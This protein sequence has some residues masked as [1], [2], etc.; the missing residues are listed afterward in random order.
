MPLSCTF[1]FFSRLQ[2]LSGSSPANPSPPPPPPP[3]PTCWSP[4]PASLLSP[5]LPDLPLLPFLLPLPCPGC[6]ALPLLPCSPPPPENCPCSCASKLSQSLK[7]SLKKT[8]WCFGDLRRVLNAN[9]LLWKC[10]N[11]QPVLRNHIMPLCSP[12]AKSQSR[13][14]KARPWALDAHIWKFSQIWCIHIW[15]CKFN[16]W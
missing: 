10:E 7:L 13:Q 15:S 9:A 11:S 6:P 14:T 2:P 5:L 1:T 16:L 8:R 3:P 12:K 4:L